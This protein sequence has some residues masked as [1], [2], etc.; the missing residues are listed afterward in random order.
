L[1]DASVIEAIESCIPL[2]PLHN[3]ANLTGIKACQK[4]M[5]GV[6]QVAVFDTAFHQTMPERAYFYA[7]PY[8]YYENNDVRR[9]GFHGTSHRYISGEAIRLLGNP[10]QSKVITCHLGNGS[11]LAAVLDGKVIDTTMGLSPLE[12]LPM[13]TRSGSIDPAIVEFIANLEKLTTSETVSILNKQSGV[14]GVSGVSSDFRDLENAFKEGNH[15]A[16]LALDLF[17]YSV[18]KYIG[19]YMAALGGVDAIVFT[20]GV[21]ENAPST[22]AAIIEPLRG[23]GIYLDAEK[24]KVRGKLTDITGEASKTRVFIIPTN[25]ELVIARDTKAL[26]AE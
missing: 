5:P 3:P 7:I 1:I 13:G 12:G 17:N 15:R 21:G 2:G 26:V 16:G 18:T 19:S 20:A 8:K 10:P 25:E 9:Y 4:A 24:N 14:L 23:L 6:P 11:S 22:R